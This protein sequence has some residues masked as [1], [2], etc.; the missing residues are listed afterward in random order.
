MVEGEALGTPI[1][2]CNYSEKIIGLRDRIK[3]GGKS[4]FHSESSLT[5]SLKYR[6]SYRKKWE[7]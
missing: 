6:I 4:G 7:D 1:T 3:A 5:Y 2:F